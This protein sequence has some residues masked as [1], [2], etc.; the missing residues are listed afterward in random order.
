MTLNLGYL[1]SGVLFGLLSG[2]VLFALI[3]LGVGYLTVTRTDTT[4]AGQL[5]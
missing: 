4:A 3:A 2:A 5:E 1:T